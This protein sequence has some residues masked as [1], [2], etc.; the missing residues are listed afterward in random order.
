MTVGTTTL[1]LFSTDDLTD[2]STNGLQHFI[3]RISAKLQKANDLLDLAFLTAQTDIYRYRQNVLNTTD[4]TR[5]AVSPVLANIASGDTAE[6]TAQ[7]IQGYLA[8]IAPPPAPPVAATTTPPPV[9]TK[10]PVILTKAIMVRQTAM[11]VSPTLLTQKIAAPVVAA[12]KPT[13]AVP[14]AVVQKV[15]VAAPQPT[16]SLPV[17]AT[18]VNATGVFKPITVGGA[19]NPASTLDIIQQSPLVGAQLNLRTL[20]IAERLAQ[21]PAQEALFY[22]IANRVAILLLLADLEITV[23]DIPILADAVPTTVT[24]PLSIADLR[25][26][27]DPV[28]SRP[29]ADPTRTALVWSL[30]NKSS[31]RYTAP[32]HESG[33]RL[34]LLGRS[35]CARTAHGDAPCGGSQNSAISGFPDFLHECAERH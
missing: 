7:N 24:V 25:T 6:A 16:L 28:Y 2:L 32:H 34:P 1:P 17:R 4:A 8:S 35:P 13:L 30:V 12:P 19:S 23:D 20:T 29:A 15:S 10:G 3:N 27:A 21:S 22:S 11:F 9:T 14:A 31:D 5:L 33:R 26:V 18:G